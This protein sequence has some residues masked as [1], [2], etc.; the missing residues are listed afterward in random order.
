MNSLKNETD[1]FWTWDE[2]V[3]VS[4]FVIGNAT[5]LTTQDMTKTTKYE[6]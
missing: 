2:N 5:L 6:N 4:L 3:K 1:F